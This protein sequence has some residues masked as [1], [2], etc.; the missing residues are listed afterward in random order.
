MFVILYLFLCCVL[1][2]LRRPCDNHMWYSVHVCLYHIR[3]L[4]TPRFCVYHI[5]YF[6][7]PDLFVL[8]I[9]YD[10]A[11]LSNN[12]ATTSDVCL[13]LTDVVMAIK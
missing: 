10:M 4:C 7:L 13:C 3:Y 5:R 11:Y 6:V 2:S 12:Q 9:Q 1:N 8:T